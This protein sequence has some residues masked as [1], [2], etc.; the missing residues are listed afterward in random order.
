LAGDPALDF[1]RAVIAPSRSIAEETA[2]TRRFDW[3]TPCFDNDHRAR[4][5][6]V[7]RSCDCRRRLPMALVPGALSP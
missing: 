2:R 6:L 1:R 4:Q 5:Q 3:R 7:L